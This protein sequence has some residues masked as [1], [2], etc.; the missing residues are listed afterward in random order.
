MTR[1][2]MG[3]GLRACANLVV[4]IAVV[5]LAGPAATQSLPLPEVPAANVATV[6]APGTLADS[7]ARYPQCRERTNGC[8][9]CVGVGNGRLGCSMPG[10]A[11]QPQGWRC[12]TDAEAP[13]RPAASD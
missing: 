9:R 7:I 12:V 2:A 3:Q 8:E 13:D 5:V 1:F 6:P 10:I 4:L 11:C